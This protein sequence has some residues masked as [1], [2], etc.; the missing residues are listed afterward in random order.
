VGLHFIFNVVLDGSGR[1]LRAFAGDYIA[2]HRAGI[3]YSRQIYEVEV[4]DQA[5]LVISS[6]SPI[7]H[8]YFQVMKGLYSA[9]VC[10]K[11]GGEILLVSPIYEGMAV[12]HR[13][14][15]EVT[16]LPLEDALNRIRKGTFVD[17]VGAAI[18]TYQ[19]RLTENFNIGVISEVLTSEEAQAL[20][21]RLHPAPSELQK[22]IDEAIG[23]IPE[24]QIGVMHQSTEVLPRVT[25]T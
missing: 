5:D 6:T 7:D 25:G 14:A 22:F 15:L 8:D 3:E 4:S 1:I 21:L 10:A 24:I 20:R 12:T 17:N 2:A 9:E 19:I 23:R 11:P 18:A 13:E 16:S